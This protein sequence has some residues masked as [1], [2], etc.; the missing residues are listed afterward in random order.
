MQ[1]SAVLLK[2]TDYA[3]LPLGNTVNF[4]LGGIT[5]AQPQNWLGKDF[6]GA[7]V[8]HDAALTDYLDNSGFVNGPQLVVI[9]RSTR[10]FATVRDAIAQALTPVQGD[11]LSNITVG[12]QPAVELV[13]N[14]TATGQTITFVAFP[15]QDK[16]VLIIFRWTTPGL[17]AATVGPTFDAM[18]KS[19][20]FGPITV[21]LM[22]PTPHP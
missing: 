4:A 12:G 1:K 22:P 14:D 9:A 7:R 19:V 8:F 21:T 20:T 18:L 6:Y 15:S 3:V 13:S 10:G 17:L 16:T 5:F 11:V 2:S